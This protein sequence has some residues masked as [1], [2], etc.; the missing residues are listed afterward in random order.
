LQEDEELLLQGAAL[1]VNAQHAVTLR[2]E[3]KLLLRGNMDV[4]QWLLDN[5]PGSSRRTE[6]WEQSY[7]LFHRQFQN[8]KNKQKQKST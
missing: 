3:E 8:N 1:S 7:H 5:L 2:L 4:L 6:L